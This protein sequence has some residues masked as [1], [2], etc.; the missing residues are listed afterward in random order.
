MGKIWEWLTLGNKLS[1]NDENSN[2]TD[3]YVVVIQLCRAHTSCICF[4]EDSNRVSFHKCTLYSKF[5]KH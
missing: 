4:H 3:L 1:R 2:L 5:M